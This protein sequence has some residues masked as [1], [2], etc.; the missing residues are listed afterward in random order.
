MKTVSGDIL[1]LPMDTGKYP[2]AVLISAVC[3]ALF[4]E[5]LLNCMRLLGIC[6]DP[7]PWGSTL[8]LVNCNYH[9][10]WLQLHIL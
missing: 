6:C 10:P 8:A 9:M 4:E 7:M 3:F 2:K 5:A 1:N